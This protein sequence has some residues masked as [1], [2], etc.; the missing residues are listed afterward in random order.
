MGDHSSVKKINTAQLASINLTKISRRWRKCKPVMKGE[1][2]R[3]AALQCELR[4]PKVTF[5]SSL[6][7]YRLSRLF[8]KKFNFFGQ[9][10]VHCISTVMYTRIG[11]LLLLNS[12]PVPVRISRVKC[13]RNSL[14]DVR[15]CVFENARKGE[16]RI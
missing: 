5:I 4:Q 3:T 1:H 8:T 11:S 12:F 6:S 13:S 10:T 14:T 15:L 7:K 16:N 9:C 2:R